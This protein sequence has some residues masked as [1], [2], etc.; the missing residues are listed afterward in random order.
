MR[1]ELALIVGVISASSVLTGCQ[2]KDNANVVNGKQLFVQE[3]GACHVLSRAGTTG[4]AGPNLDA[5]FA[6]S[7]KDGLGESTFEGVVYTQILHPNR[8]PQLNPANRRETTQ[9]M[10]ADLVTGQ[11]AKDVAAYVAQAAAVP[12]EDKGQLASVGAAQAEG[13]AEAENGVLDIPVAEA[14]LAY[15][16][17]DAR[18]P[19]GSVRF[20]S[21]NPQSVPHNIAVDGNGLD[22]KGPVVEAGGVSEITV[23]LQPGEYSFYCSVPGHREGGMEGTLTVE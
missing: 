3:C 1:R 18:T 23:D 10:P 12:G 15:R 7:R 2:L 11:D 9:Q 13:T 22:E 20:T 4:T 19:A 5:A 8:N 21:A 6:Q 17:A 14:G 16:F